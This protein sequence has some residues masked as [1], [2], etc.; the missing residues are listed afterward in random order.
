MKDTPL[1]GVLFFSVIPTYSL[2]NYLS[3]TITSYQ[4]NFKK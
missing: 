2:Q 4:I 3:D 1:F